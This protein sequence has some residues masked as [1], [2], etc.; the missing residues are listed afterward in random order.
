MIAAKLFRI[1]DYDP[2]KLIESLSNWRE[3]IEREGRTL[4]TTFESLESSG[5]EVSGTLAR[6]R[7]VR[8]RSRRG[9]SLT[10]ETQYA[11]FLTFKVESPFIMVFGGRKLAEFVAFKVTEALKREGEFEHC[12]LPEAVLESLSEGTRVAHFE[13]LRGLGIRKIA[14][15]GENLEDLNLY[16]EIKRLGRLSYIQFYSSELGGSVGLS[17]DFSII[18][19]GGV[20]RRSLVEYV[21]SL[22]TEVVC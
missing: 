2:S 19:Y 5:D 22:L 6:D 9:I 10:V 15:Y 11:D 18:A 14:I 17:K 13:D 7:L 20:D 3:E 1:P 8:R 21:R 4:L 12:V 16:K